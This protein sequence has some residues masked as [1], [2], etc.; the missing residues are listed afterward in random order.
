MNTFIHEKMNIDTNGLKP[1]RGK[2]DLFALVI[3]L[4][5]LL[6]CKYFD[7]MIFELRNAI[8]ELSSVLEVIT[9]DA[10]LDVMGF[11]ENWQHIRTL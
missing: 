3:I 7:K 8:A 9:I 4:K 6:E 1:M 2:N 10:V 11:P 5:L